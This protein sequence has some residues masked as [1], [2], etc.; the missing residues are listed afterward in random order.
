MLGEGLRLFY[1]VTSISSM[2][3]V[4][5]AIYRCISVY[6]NIHRCISAWI[7]L[8]TYIMRVYTVMYIGVY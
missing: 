3:S 4:D 7:V 6:C 2:I 8:D 5:V 1:S